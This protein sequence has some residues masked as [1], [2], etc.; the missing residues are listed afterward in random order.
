MIRPSHNNNELLI[1]NCF[2]Y[3]TYYLTCPIVLLIR[4]YPIIT[5]AK[6]GLELY[7]RYL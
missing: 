2:N 1:I 7:T 6:Y 5:I 4:A 3:L